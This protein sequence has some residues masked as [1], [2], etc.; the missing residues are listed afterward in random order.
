[1]CAKQFGHRS[2]I[3]KWSSPL[4]A[5]SCT[6]VQ[7]Y[8]WKDRHT[9]ILAGW[10]FRQSKQG[11]HCA[12]TLS[13]RVKVSWTF[14]FRY[15][16]GYELYLTS[17]QSLLAF[18][19]SLSSGAHEFIHESCTPKWWYSVFSY[20][21]AFWFFI[22][23]LRHSSYPVDICLFPFQV[24]F[25]APSFSFCSRIFSSF[26]YLS[27][28]FK[29]ICNSYRMHFTLSLCILLYKSICVFLGSS[30]WY[31][32]AFLPSH[33]TV[34]H[35]WFPIRSVSHLPLIFSNGLW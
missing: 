16:L 14:M 33:F 25:C 27:F 15:V 13:A 10:A 20:L 6:T 32:Y 8:R 22:C 17:A 3:R 11:P 35:L 21:S 1:M 7:E 4:A 5:L 30:A 12:L 26:S 24:L 31:F 23:R 19:C 29:I 18:E 34:G 2:W 28:I 9:S